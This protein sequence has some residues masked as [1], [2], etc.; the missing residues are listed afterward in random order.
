MVP[1]RGLA[2]GQSVVQEAVLGLACVLEGFRRACAGLLLLLLAELTSC[3]LCVSKAPAARVVTVT[4]C[5]S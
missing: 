1:W 5:E 4:C 3:F 2:M